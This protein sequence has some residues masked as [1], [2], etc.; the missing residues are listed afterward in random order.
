[1]RGRYIQEQVWTRLGSRQMDIAQQE[2]SGK[3]LQETL[4]RNKVILFLTRDLG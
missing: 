2:K 4:E 3:T 1:M